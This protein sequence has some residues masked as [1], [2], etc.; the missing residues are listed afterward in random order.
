MSF[1]WRKKDK[2]GKQYLWQIDIE[3]LIILLVF[4]LL[5]ALVGPRLFRHSKSQ[6]KQLD[7]I[8]SISSQEFEGFE[9]CKISDK[10]SATMTRL[11]TD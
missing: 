1:W 11:I 4:G 7:T 9:K 2:S 8:Y 6:D 10:L 5:A 3:P